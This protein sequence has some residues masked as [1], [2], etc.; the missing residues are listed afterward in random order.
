[1]IRW[2]AASALAGAVLLLGPVLVH[3]LL[4][5]HARRV[6]FPATRFLPA[7]HAAAVRFRR[8]SDVALMVL[9]MGIVAA[10][11]SA[12][13]QPLVITPWRVSQ[14]NNR[15]FRA[16]VVDTTMQGPA[17]DDTARLAQQ[18]MAGV[19]GQRFDSAD[20][21]DALRRAGSW[22]AAA[23]PGRREAVILSDFTVGSIDADAFR[24]LPAGVGVR[25]IRAGVPPPSREVPLAEATGF[26]GGVWRPSMRV[27]KDGTSMTWTRVGTATPPAWLETSQAPGDNAAAERA[28]RAAA[29]FGIA[30]GDD[31]Q[32]VL[33][34][35]SEVRQPTTDNRRPTTDDRRVR[36]PWMVR[37][38][39]ALRESTLLAEIGV[40]VT[41]GDEQ[42]R[43]VVDAAIPASDSTAAAVLRAVILAV[44]PASIA[45]HDAEVLT[46]SDADLAAWRREPGPA[47]PPAPG[48]LGPSDARWLWA[49]SLLLLAIETWI[50]RTRVETGTAEARHAA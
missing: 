12:A 46:L 14:W 41:T 22:F 21:R 33:V 35:F 38:A 17:V 28:L 13:A 39:L 10:A 45:S 30:A 7:T 24:V 42:R 11:V 26:R 37:A 32:R 31:R 20:L 25:F 48:A 5:R 19:Q 23:P 40:H 36:E 50:R 47:E 43:L 34:R 49:L 18:E 15:V 1:V 27:A 44:R 16:V 8:P 9:R 29:S 3:M 2:T 6:V 4:R